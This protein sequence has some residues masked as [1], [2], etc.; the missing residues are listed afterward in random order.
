M[1]KDQILSDISKLAAKHAL[2]EDSELAYYFE[3]E[4]YV[5]IARWLLQ[6]KIDTGTFVLTELLDETSDLFDDRFDYLSD[7]QLAAI[8]EQAPFYIAPEMKELFLFHQQ[9]FWPDTE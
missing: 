3:L 1:T 6:E 8:S 2:E 5:L 4:A 9:A 7:L